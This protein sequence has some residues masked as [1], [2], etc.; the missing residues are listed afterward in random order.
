MLRLVQLLSAIASPLSQ[1]SRWEHPGMP[2]QSGMGQ[3][4]NSPGSDIKEE[5]SPESLGGHT[6]LEDHSPPHPSAIYA[7]LQKASNM[8]ASV[9]TGSMMHSMMG[10]ITGRHINEVSERKNKNP[11]TTINNPET[12]LIVSLLNVAMHGQNHKD[13]LDTSVHYSSHNV[14]NRTPTH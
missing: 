10:A 14:F 13:K 6:K 3:D 8:G 7:D 1:C 11:E 2:N 4:P 9:P 5:H 12:R